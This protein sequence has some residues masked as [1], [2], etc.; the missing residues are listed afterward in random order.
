MQIINKPIVLHSRE[1]KNKKQKE[2]EYICNYQK[3]IRV[4]T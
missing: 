3:K 1:A 4:K 2:K